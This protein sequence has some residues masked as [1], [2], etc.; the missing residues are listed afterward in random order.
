[1]KLNNNP[2]RIRPL[3]IEIVDAR[4]INLRIFGSTIAKL[5]VLL[6]GLITKITTN[7]AL[8]HKREKII[9]IPWISAINSLIKMRH[10]NYP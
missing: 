3:T 6:A 5:P 8:H 4:I 10:D 1:M 7:V 9:W 2:N